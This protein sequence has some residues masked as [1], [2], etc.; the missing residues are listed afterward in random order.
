[1][2]PFLAALETSWV[3]ENL[4][5]SRWGYAAVSGAHILG[6]AL[7]VGGILPLDLRLLGLWPSTH[8]ADI[9]RVLV[10]TAAS[11]LALAA[12]TGAL[13][14]SVRAQDYWAID[15]FR[16]KLAFILAGTVS[17][18]L[19]HRSYGLTLEAANPRRLRWSAL[20][21]MACW[22]GALASGRAIAF[23]D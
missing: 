3:A 23:V 18:V 4:R 2:E 21:S 19:I 16:A 12:I 5:V 6:I 7:L 14:F 13:L 1:M 20:F 17:A 10:A 9:V 11:G 8:R 22:I 15:F